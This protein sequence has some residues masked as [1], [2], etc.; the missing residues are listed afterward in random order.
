MPHPTLDKFGA[1]TDSMPLLLKAHAAISVTF[2]RSIFFKD[3]QLSNQYPPIIYGYG[4]VMDCK[5]VQF[6]NMLTEL[7]AKS[8]PV[9]YLNPLN[10]VIFVLASQS[11][12]GLVT[13]YASASVIPNPSDDTFLDINNCST[14]GSSKS[15]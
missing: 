6:L 9:K 2:E 4:I 15:I 10:D 7:Q 13:A 11:V 14:R 8:N 5:L 3:V 1:Y 12:P